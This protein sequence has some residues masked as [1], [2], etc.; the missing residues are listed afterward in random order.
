[1]RAF[2]L[3]IAVLSITPIAH[4]EVEALP[5]TLDLA[6]GTLPDGSLTLANHGMTTLDLEIS[7]QDVDLRPSGARMLSPTD[8]VVALPATMRLAPGETR[9]ITVGVVSAPLAATSYRVVV[10]GAASATYLE[11]PVL[12]QPRR[13]PLSLASAAA[14][15][16][17]SIAA[18]RR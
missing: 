18:P 6:S 2:L 1:M 14:Q 8:D 3:A 5:R 10:S 17:L 15:R 4:A 12:V 13:G 9:T 7:A 16:G 11:I